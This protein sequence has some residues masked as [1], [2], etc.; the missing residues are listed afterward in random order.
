M[1][2]GLNHLTLSVSN[3][4]TSFNFYTSV[5]GFKPL[6]KWKKGAYLLAGELWLCLSLDSDNYLK[7][8]SNYTHFAFSISPKDFE[9]YRQNLIELNI[10]FWK[11]NSSEGSSLYILDPDNHKLELHVGSWQ[12]R[13]LAIKQHPYEDMVFFNTSTKAK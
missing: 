3:L 12:T 13:L 11:E 9:R 2:T 6:A 4:E 1:I 7:I 5:L 10:K 8:S